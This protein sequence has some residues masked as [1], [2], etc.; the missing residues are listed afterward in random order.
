MVRLRSTIRAACFGKSLFITSL[1][2]NS[3]G[4]T[5]VLI[6]L[7]NSETT[8]YYNDFLP[9]T[10]EGLTTGYGGSAAA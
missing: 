8:Y 10:A 5:F 9:Y 2:Y 3:A 4:S 1:V 7:C 6:A